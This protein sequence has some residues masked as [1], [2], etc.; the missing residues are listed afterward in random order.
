[1]LQ[2]LSHLSWFQL[3]LL[4]LAINI[5]LFASSVGLYALVKMFSTQELIQEQ[6]QKFSKGDL[7]LAILVLVCNS[8]VFLLGEYLWERG[9]II[10][11]EKESVFTILLQIGVL[12]GGMDFL[13]YVFHRIAHLPGLYGLVHGKHHEHSSV[14]F[15]SLFVLHPVEA[16]G[17]GM[18][19][20]VLLL[21]YPFNVWAITAYLTINLIWGTI[22][23][24]NQE[25]LK[26]TRFK[27]WIST[28]LCLSVFHNRHHQY[29]DCNYGFYTLLWDKVCKTYR[30]ES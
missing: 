6:E 8:A 11:S 3:L 18:L 30:T 28:V 20:I 10:V 5:V 17:F 27:Q 29:P 22:G 26:E 24:L 23:H 15:L 4:S 12:V 19:F 16:I 7:Q 21:I 1:M 13:M 2:T 9:F 25:I 14:N